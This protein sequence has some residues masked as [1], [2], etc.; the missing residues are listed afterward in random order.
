MFLGRCS[1]INNDDTTVNTSLLVTSSSNNNS[2]S[3]N[4]SH[5]NSNPIADLSQPRTCNCRIPRNCPVGNKCITKDVIYSATVYSG[6]N[7]HK[8][9]GATSTT[10]N[11]SGD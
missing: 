11:R 4:H 1:I 7:V 2:N 6:N 3:G 8:Y 10:F 9:I 5:F